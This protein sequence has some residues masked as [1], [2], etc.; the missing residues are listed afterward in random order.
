[1]FR[2]NEAHLQQD[3]LSLE[4]VL[5]PAA[6]RRLEESKEHAFYE[7]LFCRIPED[8]FAD[9]YS[10]NPASRP[11]API[12]VLV[13]ALLLQHMNNWTFEELF[14]RLAFDLKTR[15]ALGCWTLDVDLFCPATLFNFQRRFRDHMVRAG[16]NKFELLFDRFTQ[17]DLARIDLKTTIQRSDSTQIGSF[18]REYT[19]IELVVEVLLRMWRV[20]SEQDQA[21]YQER[22]APYVSQ[23]SGQFLHR[24]RSSD[25]GGTLESLAGLYAWMVDTLGTGYGSC[26]IYGIVR[27]VFEEQFTRSAEKIAVRASSDISSA[28][29]QSPDDPEATYRHKSDE[30]HHGYVL[31]ATESAHP[32]NPL[33]IVVDLALA[34][35]N[36]DDAAILHERLPAMQAKTPGLVELHTDATYGS[37]RNDQLMAERN[38]D[39]VQTAFRGRISPAPL[40]ITALPDGRFEVRC[41]AGHVVASQMT[42]MR[43]KAEFQA[44]WCAHCPLAAVCPANTRSGG[45]KTYYFDQTNVL[46]QARRDRLLNLP[47]DRLQLRANIEATMQEFKTPTRNGKLRTRGRAAATQHVFLRAITINFGRIHRYLANH[48][49]NTPPT[50]RSTGRI[51]ITAL[52]RLGFQRQLCLYRY[53]LRYVGAWL[54]SR[55][56][57]PTV[58]HTQTHTFRQ[59]Y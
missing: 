46:R 26:E 18:I 47:P 31:H 14:D 35:N 6:R 59:A 50:G 25:L 41:A 23:S 20:L 56:L 39:H 7:L 43:Q 32:D 44:E 38:I 13:G 55:F 45:G 22:F 17:E 27:R 34:T 29:L 52:F 19:R 10:A 15:I 30:N 49:S 40:H 42:R 16:V 57:L 4:H 48:A 53:T 37:T 36:Q 9:L 58:K 3:L 33:Q 12:N 28:S 51:S 11:N 8:L 1:M 54:L 2:S 5:P 21:L 24:L